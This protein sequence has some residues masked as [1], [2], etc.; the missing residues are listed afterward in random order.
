MSG[1]LVV[2]VI[3]V[4]ELAHHACNGCLEKERL[5]LLEVK[6][7][8]NAH[9]FSIDSL[10]SW[11]GRN[12]CEW[13]G[14][15][16]HSPTPH[17]LRL[18][19]S[20]LLDIDHSQHMLYLFHASLLNPFPKLESLDLSHNA[21]S[22]FT[23]HKYLKNLRELT[24]NNNRFNDSKLLQ[25]LCKT[26]HL[27]KLDISSNNFSGEFPECVMNISSL[28]FLDISSNQFTGTLPSTISTLKSIK[29]LQLDDNNFQ[30]TFSMALLANLSNLKVFQLSTK[31]TNNL[32][33]QTETP[34]FLPTFQ[35][36][37]LKLSHC[38]LNSKT[39]SKIPMFLMSQHALKFLDL[40]HNNLVGTFPVWLLKNNTD[41]E[42]LILTNNSL[43]ATLHL[44]PFKHH[45]LHLRLSC[46]TLH[47]HL[48][49]HM[50]FLLPSLSHFNVSRNSFEGNI[51]LS[52]RKLQSLN[53]FDLSNNK[54]SGK[55]RMSIF[56]SMPE[57]SRLQ[58]GN[59]NFSGNIEDELQDSPDLIVLDISENRISGSIPRWI[60]NLTD[61]LY[62]QL[63][64]NHLKGKLPIELCSLQFLKFFDV[65]GN[66]LHGSIPSCFNIPSLNYLYMQ[67][68]NF[69]GPIPKAFSKS[70]ELVAFDLSQNRFSGHIPSWINKFS[71]LQFLLL[72]G[73]HLR[74]SIPRH[75]CGLREMSIMDLSGNKLKGSIPSCLGNMSFGISKGSKSSYESM[76]LDFKSVFFV[77]I[78]VLFDGKGMFWRISHE[79]KYSEGEIE[80]NFMTKNRL[81]QYK[82]NILKYMC[83]LDLSNNEL[84]GTIPPQIG[85]LHKIHAL[86][87]SHNKLK[88]RIPET[89]CEL[90]QMESLDLSYNLL[91]GGIPSNLSQLDF[92]SF[93]NVSYNNLSGVIP[94]SPHFRT[95][96]E[97]SYL[98]NPN[99]CG[100]VAG[101]GCSSHKWKPRNQ[102]EGLMRDEDDKINEYVETFYWSFVASYLMVLLGLVIVLFVNPRWRGI[103]FYFVHLCCSYLFNYV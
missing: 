85:Y 73:N 60:G 48:P 17:I 16:C 49:Y 7:F 44:P 68:N 3:L 37:V 64:Q 79:D 69:S 47:G 51:P 66:Q 80:V 81:E 91:S 40:S 62:L 65:S 6:R 54:F 87:F 12:C 8:F 72:K 13:D 52:I 5:G 22:A 4:F 25:E 57:L 75:V 35:L 94:M 2:A 43:T 78:D 27:V 74:G 77:E 33:V 28:E 18:S 89:L 24:L 63:S 61:L 102:Y 88:G 55:I 34:S 20:T 101:K 67:H 31:N 58:L 100:V 84:S 50:G 9:N 59:N 90:K 96:V 56:S 30:G 39:S 1:R 98:G 86:N 71:S 29:I 11:S 26:K 41:L 38:N 82:G 99:L 97:G 70:K 32:Q 15:Q 21:F 95:F 10:P 14:V 19:L 42:Y 36:N 103:W 23:N 53:I 46:N 92:L 45:L 76:G 83:G 93:F